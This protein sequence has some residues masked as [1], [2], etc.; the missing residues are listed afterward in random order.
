MFAPLSAAFYD[1][2]AQQVAPRLLGALMVHQSDQGLTAGRV[3]E[4]EAYLATG[5]SAN[6]AA[7]GRTERNAAMFGPPGTAYV[8]FVYGMHHC[9][10]VVCGPVDVPEA[11]LVRALEPTAGIELMAARR[12][13]ERLELLASGPARLCQALGITREHDGADITRGPLYLAEGDPPAGKVIYTTRVGC[14]STPHLRLRWYVR[15]SPC[16]SS[17]DRAAEGR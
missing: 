11:V 13:T 9:F 15:D 12:G 8:Y 10:N 6:H 17:R 5:D 1:R 14:P 2:P 7:R 4:V 3:V 16:V